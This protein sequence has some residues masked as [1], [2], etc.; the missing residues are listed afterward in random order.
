MKKRLIIIGEIALL[1]GVWFAIKY[2]VRKPEITTESTVSFVL[3]IAACTGSVL[4][5]H[6]NPDQ[7]DRDDPDGK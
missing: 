1:V 6:R 5:F 7:K 2:L 4:Y 3:Y